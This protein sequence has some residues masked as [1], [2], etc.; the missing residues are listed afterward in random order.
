[1]KPTTT[2]I[3]LTN[4]RRDPTFANLVDEF[5]AYALNQPVHVQRSLIRDAFVALAGLAADEVLDADSQ[6]RRSN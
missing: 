4:I 2:T 1:M 6:A 3:T 5:I